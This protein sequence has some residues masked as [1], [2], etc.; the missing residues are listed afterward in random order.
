M[1]KKDFQKVF[2]NHM[3]LLGFNFKGL[4]GTKV[5][6]DDYEIYVNLEHSSYDTEYRVKYGV[7][8]A[9]NDDTRKGFLWDY[10]FKL[11][12][13]RSPDDD[14]SLVK[15]LGSDEQYASELVTDL[16]NYKERTLEEF[17]KLLE[18]NIKKYLIPMYD[19]EYI[20]NKYR[21]RPSL[22]CR[23]P[24]QTVVRLVEL[25]GLDVNEVERATNKKLT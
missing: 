9:P 1:E 7:S 22:L 18:L 4:C 15:H 5:I 20:L 2:K 11:T 3:K 21:R 24:K 17:F 10:S 6:S 12:F 25:A 8:Y 19:K 13:T 16:F 14:I 23:Y